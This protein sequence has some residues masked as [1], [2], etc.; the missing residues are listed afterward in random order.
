MNQSNGDFSL[1]ALLMLSPHLGDMG[2]GCGWQIVAVA[3]LPIQAF[4][5]PDPQVGSQDPSIRVDWLL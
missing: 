5:L 1:S 2:V 3:S 4:R